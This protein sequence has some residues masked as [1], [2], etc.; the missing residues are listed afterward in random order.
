MLKKII[1]VN[2]FS[3]MTKKKMTFIVVWKVLLSTQYEPMY[4]KS[5][6][7]SVSSPSINLVLSKIKSMNSENHVEFFKYSK[8]QFLILSIVHTM[9]TRTFF[10]D[11]I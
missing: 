3:E 2:V 11:Q 9:L 1:I 8:L 6:N 10:N 4:P 7:G 5:D